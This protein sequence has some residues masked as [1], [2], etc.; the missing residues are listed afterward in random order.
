MCATL[1]DRAVLAMGG[2]LD[3]QFFETV[4]NAGDHG[5]DQWWLHLGR[6]AACGQHWLIGQEE[7]IYDCIC[8]RRLSFQEAEEIT[9]RGEWPDDFQTYEALLRLGCAQGWTVTFLD[10][11]SGPLIDTAKD[12]RASRPEIGDAEIGAL[13]GLTAKHAAAL[14]RP[15]APLRRLYRRLTNTGS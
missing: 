3:E 4:G 15:E 6:C 12:L 10:R 11:R 9:G 5:G 8:L 7:R 14:F 13:L 1:D 2:E